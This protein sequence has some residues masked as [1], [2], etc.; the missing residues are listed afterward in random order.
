MVQVGGTVSFLANVIWFLCLG[1]E[2]FLIHICSAVLLTIT[3]VGIPFA[4]QSV[5]LAMIS[6]APFG[7]QVIKTH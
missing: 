1:W 3:I 7:Y 5:K 2:L 4:K 6:L